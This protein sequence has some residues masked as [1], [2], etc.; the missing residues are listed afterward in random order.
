MKKKKI[1]II[2][3]S[4]I[5]SLILICAVCLIPFLL[6][7]K[8]SNNDVLGTISAINLNYITNLE[9]DLTNAISIGISKNLSTTS[10]VSLVVMNVN[11]SNKKANIGNPPWGM[12]VDCILRRKPI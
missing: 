12:N 4:T 1:V 8:K 5:C 3:I 10:Q 2:S 9:M 11:D 7:K 6:K